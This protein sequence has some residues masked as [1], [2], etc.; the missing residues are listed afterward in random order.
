[1]H[2]FRYES[3]DCGAG[4]GSDRSGLR[5]SCL[6]LRL[7]H[8]SEKGR[9]VVLGQVLQESSLQSFGVNMNVSRL[10]E[11]RRGESVR[12]MNVFLE[13]EYVELQHVI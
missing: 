10:L 8:L 11:G 3:G 12:G 5:L 1:M 2:L 4:C 9:E 13:A 7:A 6:S